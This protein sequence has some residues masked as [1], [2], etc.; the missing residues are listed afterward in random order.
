MNKRIIKQLYIV[1]TRRQRSIGDIIAILK[2]RQHLQFVCS[3]V[4]C[5]GD[6]KDQW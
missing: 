1:D 5:D 3:T 2:P 4:T 6:G